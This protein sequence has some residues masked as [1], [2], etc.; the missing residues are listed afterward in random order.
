MATSKPASG[1]T[2]E[3]P[4]PMSDGSRARTV[5][6]RCRKLASFSQDS[7]STRRTFLSAPMR[8]CHREITAWL[9]PLGA[10]GKIDAAGNLRAFY[11]AAEPDALRLLIGSH[12]DT[13]PNAGAFDGIL[14]VVLGVALLEALE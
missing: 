12:L 6:E 3:S 7:G 9:K 2:D 1:G 11:G 13:V 10:E 14:G 4:S 8:D 5:I